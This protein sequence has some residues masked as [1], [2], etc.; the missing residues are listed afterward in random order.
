LLFSQFDSVALIKF[1]KFITYH[2][3]FIEGDVVIV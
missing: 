3:Q 2:L 1:Q